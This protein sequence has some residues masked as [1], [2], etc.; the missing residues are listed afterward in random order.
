M[1]DT[2]VYISRST[3]TTEGNKTGTW[4]FLRP[5]YVEKTAP[6]SAACP[7][8]E[9]IGRIEMLAARGDL[10][11]ALETVL[12]ENPFPAVCGRVCFHPCENVCNRA[13]YD[14]AVAVHHLERFVGDAGIGGGGAPTPAVCPP[15][16]RRVA[17]AGA[18][19]AG[20]AAAYFLKILGCDCDV[21]EA[22]SEPGGILRWG[23][24]AY[25]LP[26]RV[27]AAEIG[28]I[29]RIGVNLH[30]ATPVT[31]TML[32]E[33]R[34]RYDAVFVGCGQGRS[35]RLKVPGADM[36][37]DGLALLCRVR[38]GSTDRVRGSVA[39][40]GGGNTAV[41]VSRTLVRLGAD[42]VM[43]YRRQRRDMPAFA[44]E[45]AAALAEGVRL[46]ELSAPV[47]MDTVG[48]GV[49]LTV[50]P[51]RP[52]DVGPGGRTRVAPDALPA[53]VLRLSGVYTAIG[54]AAESR[55]Q[56]PGQPAGPVPGLTH[57][58]VAETDRPLIFGGDLTNAERSVPDAVASGKQAAMALD[59]YF[60]SGWPAVAPALAAC[61]VG[62]GSALSMAAYLHRRVPA[63]TSH[64]VR[65]DAINTDYFRHSPRVDVPAPDPAVSIRSF[66]ETG[67]TLSA[68]E[69]AVEA[70]RCFNCGVC[71]GCD[72]CRVFCPEVAV[73][74]DGRHRRIHTDYCK[75][76]GICVTECPRSAMDLVEENRC[77]R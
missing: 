4:R 22:A 28:R 12:V 52:V 8:G 26:G 54:A 56:H 20:L 75:G 37:E 47:R 14:T 6:C 34:E 43:V 55:W 30:C 70:A 15:S 24:P 7:A 33:L 42:V 39:V 60:K 36:A 2:P 9:D 77:E 45:V 65:F 69:A 57:C 67:G 49:A 25:R 74:V 35:I 71:N 19:P 5:E 61:R 40:I 32:R 58:A 18:G 11:G 51:M 68:P 21:F 31:G 23:I 73:I 3:T 62:D 38:R 59:A 29:E 72:H 63:K 46:M 53:Q 66:A 27:L 17:V 64:V 10:Q 76:C 50:Q 1:D 41:D 44:G 16:G 13:E 48:S